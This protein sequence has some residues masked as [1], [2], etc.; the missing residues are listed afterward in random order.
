MKIILFIIGIGI[1][2]DATLGDAQRLKPWPIDDISTK[3]PLDLCKW[4]DWQDRDNPSGRCDCEE[5]PK[6]CKVVKYQIQLTSGGT[7]WTDIND[8]SIPN[9]F[10]NNLVQC[11]NRDQPGCPVN[12]NGFPTVCPL[13]KECCRD[14]RVKFCCAPMIFELPPLETESDKDDGNCFQLG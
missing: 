12:S 10:T 1:F 14:Y 3:P 7:I 4:T 8:P 6:R 5:A 11:F 9:V 13:P 2:I